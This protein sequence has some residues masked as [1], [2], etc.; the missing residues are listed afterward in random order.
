MK[1]DRITQEFVLKRYQQRS[2]KMSK[3]AS[4]VG[5]SE[6]AGCWI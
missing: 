2:E 1:R 3:A 5:A 6:G 4:E